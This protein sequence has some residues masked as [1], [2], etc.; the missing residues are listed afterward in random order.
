MKTIIRL[1]VLALFFGNVNTLFSQTPV[2]FDDCEYDMFFVSAEEKP[3]WR[4]DSKTLEDYFNNKIADNESIKSVEGKVI[5]GILILKDGKTC[6]HSF[7]DLTTSNLDPKI[8]KEIV[9]EMPD[10]IPAKQNGKN[11]IFLNNLM[12]EI[13]DG[14]I[15]I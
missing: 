11:I 14:K 6:C 12:I 13:K 2:N 3:Q 9:D 10:W 4:I 15:E 8:F 7:T 1:L 5:L